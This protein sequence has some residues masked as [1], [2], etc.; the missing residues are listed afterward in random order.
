MVES[1]AIRRSPLA[2]RRIVTKGFA[3]ILDLICMLM[4]MDVYLLSYSLVLSPPASL[5]VVPCEV[6][7]SLGR[8]AGGCS[9]YQVA[10]RLHLSFRAYDESKH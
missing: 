5:R 8:N 3:V 7:G 9:S 1:E 6:E 2:A 4:V 10:L